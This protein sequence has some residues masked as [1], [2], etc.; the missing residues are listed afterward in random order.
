MLNVSKN[1]HRW[2]MSLN[3]SSQQALEGDA[4]T[5][6]WTWK[7]DMESPKS[8]PINTDYA[9]W[10]IKQRIRNSK[11]SRPQTEQKLSGLPPPPPPPKQFSKLVYE[12]TICAAYEDQNAG[13]YIDALKQAALGDHA[14]FHKILNAIDRA[15]LIEHF[16]LDAAPKPRNHFLHRNLLEIADLLGVSDMKHEGILEFLDD[17]CPCGKMHRPDAI[18]KLRKRVA[19]KSDSKR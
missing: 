18:R 13:R 8:Y 11:L 5:L 12:G 10:Q 15:Y 9:F 19:P 17:L 7:R 2:K 4:E 16:G 1:K 14:A 6:A 3:E